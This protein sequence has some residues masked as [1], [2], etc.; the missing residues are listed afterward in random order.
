MSGPTGRATALSGRRTTATVMA[1]VVVFVV[2]AV[3]LSLRYA[4]SSGGEGRLMLV[5]QFDDASPL[6]EGN[7]VRIDGVKVGRVTSMEIVEDG[8]EVGLELDAAALPVYRDASVTI[9][10]VSLLGE[11]YVELDPGTPAAQPMPDR[12]TIAQDR[13]GASTDL[14][15]VLNVFDEPTGEA[16]RAMIATLG[17]GLDGNG[18]NVTRILQQLAPAMGQTEEL[19]G[20]LAEQNDVLT[21]LVTSMD[22][23]VGGLATDQGEALDRLVST[24]GRLLDSTAAEDEAFRALVQELPSTLAA[25]RRTLGELEATSEATT[26]N[27]RAMRP[28]TESLEEMAGELRAFSEAADPAMAAVNPVLREAE[29]LLAETRPVAEL[30]R[31]QAPA[32]QGDAQALDRIVDELAPGFRTIMEFFRGWAL[33]TNSRD[34]LGHYFRAG[35]VISPYAVTG[36]LGES[37]LPDDDVLEDLGL[38]DLGLEVPDLGALLPDLDLPGLPTDGLVGLL[39]GGREAGTRDRDREGAGGGGGLGLPLSLLSGRTTAKGGVTGLNRE[40]EQAALGFLL[41]GS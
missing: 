30:L 36:N 17:G 28:A 35:F 5:A 41:G 37:T 7:D 34:G 20:V 10:P 2:S 15:Q 39:G 18:K 19:A 3:A 13:T 16:M 27:L 29:D 31:R 1:L 40:Q 6:L 9:R 23:V 22:R 21:R 32:L 12:G 38:P 25:A 26:P 33:S 24:T 11:R 8:A 14:D 4:G